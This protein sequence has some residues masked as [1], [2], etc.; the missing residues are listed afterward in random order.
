MNRRILSYIFLIIVVAVN[1]YYLPLTIQ[2]IQSGG[3][4]FGFGVLALPFTCGI[5]LLLITALLSIFKFGNNTLTTINSIGIVGI[6][7][8]SYLIYT[9]P[10][11]RPAN[12]RSLIVT[13]N[14]VTDTIT[15]ESVL[16]EDSI[17]N[18]GT[19]RFDPKVEFEII[20]F[21]H[22][23][24]HETTDEMLSMCDNWQLTS[25]Q[26]EHIIRTLKPI[27]GSQWNYEFGQYPC[28]Y[29]GTINQNRNKVKFSINSGSWFTVTSDTTIYY[30]DVKG[31]LVELFL[32]E[33]WTE[34]DYQ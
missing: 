25:S 15:Y 33:V 8:L 10:E 22:L 23:N 17:Q 32:D 29:S 14:G 19:F 21:E 4:A 1:F 24:E 13:S 31:R 27:N 20:D 28:Y 18:R 16:R 11:T 3:G 7:L 12:E 5:N 6:A 30:G 26:I 2:I 34:E 9:I